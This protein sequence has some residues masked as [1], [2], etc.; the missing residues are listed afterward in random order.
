MVSRAFCMQ[1]ESYTA[2]AQRMT[3]H[4]HRRG[5]P[6]FA[7]RVGFQKRQPMESGAA[8]STGDIHSDDYR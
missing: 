3:A 2:T 6:V 4:K 5:W 7:G 1:A 8:A